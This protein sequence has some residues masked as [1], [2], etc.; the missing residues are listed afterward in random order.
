M[1]IYIYIYIYGGI[2]RVV[3]MKTFFRSEFIE[4]EIDKRLDVRLLIIASQSC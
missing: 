4:L 3:Q 1:Y 2:F